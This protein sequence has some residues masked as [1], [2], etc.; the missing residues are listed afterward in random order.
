MIACASC[1]RHFFIVVFLPVQSHVGAPVP[2]SSAA[3]I[4]QHLLGSFDHRHSFSHI[5]GGWTSEF[6]RPA[7]LGF[8]ENPFLELHSA[9]FLPY[10]LVSPPLLTRVPTLRNGGPTLM[11][12]FNLY[13]LLTGPIS[14]HGPTGDSG[15]DMNLEGNSPE[16]PTCLFFFFFKLY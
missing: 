4:E 7:W 12:S 5:S 14:K 1:L 16:Q 10:P 11:T 13:H 6:R 8:S 15:F 2:V 3:V 9:T